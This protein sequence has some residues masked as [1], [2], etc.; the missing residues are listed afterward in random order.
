V[1]LLNDQRERKRE[2]TNV[3]MPMPCSGPCKTPFMILD[4]MPNAGENLELE[5][6]PEK[7]RINAE[8]MRKSI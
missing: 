4:M 2:K 6:A 5:T 3:M 7:C 8:Y 1:I